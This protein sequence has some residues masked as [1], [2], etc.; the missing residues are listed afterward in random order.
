MTEPTE[1]VKDAELRITEELA[2]QAHSEPGSWQENE[3]KERRAEA[4]RKMLE[5]QKPK[6]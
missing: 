4:E 1:K 5:A 6:K 3:A 2:N